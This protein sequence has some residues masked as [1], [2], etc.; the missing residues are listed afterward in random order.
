MAMLSKFNLEF[1]AQKFTKE[2]ALDFLATT[3]R[4]NEE[5][6]ALPDEDIIQVRHKTWQMYL[7]GTSNHKGYR[8]GILLVS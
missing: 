6:C 4:G 3:H 7:C 8:V 2:G 5:S 1:N